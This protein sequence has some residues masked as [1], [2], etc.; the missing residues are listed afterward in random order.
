MLTSLGRVSQI[1]LTMPTYLLHGFRWQRAAIRIHIIL[2]DLEDAAPEWIV[3][4][5]TSN[6]ILNSFYSLFDFL[7]P[8]N[9]PAPAQPP[10]LPMDFPPPP[11]IPDD[12]PDERPSRLSRKNTRSMVSLRSLSRKRRPANIGTAPMIK[13]SGERKPSTSTSDSGGHKSRPATSSGSNFYSPFIN[14][15]PRKPPAFNDWSVVKL[16]EQYDPND[17]QSTSQP[18]AYVADYM[19][20]VT[21]GISLAEEMAK[22]EL[23]LK[24]EDAPMSTPASPGSAHASTSSIGDLG[25]LGLSARDVRRKSRRLGWFEKLR[26]GL[27]K[28]EDIGWHVVVCGDEERASPSID[29]LR[30][31]RP[32]TST[33]DSTMHRL[34]R[35]AGLRS[36][37]GRRRPEISE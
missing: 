10:S 8:S 11:P 33:S 35:S 30:N 23:R 26:D 27:Q 6:T 13:P 9:P 28:G 21:L 18:Y 36:F 37:F 16:V 5:A 15:K 17:M 19:V 31:G 22:Y 25:S 2:Q 14:G 24:S 3:A 4:P 7:P 1:P 32:S 29:I 34:P 20:E 12:P